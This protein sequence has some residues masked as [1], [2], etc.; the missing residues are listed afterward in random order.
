MMFLPSKKR[1]RLL[2][3]G[4]V[5]RVRIGGVVK[6]S[7]SSWPSLCLDVRFPFAVNPVPTDSKVSAFAVSSGGN[8]VLHV[9]RP[10]RWAKIAYSVVGPVSVD[11]VGVVL[12]KFA[13][14][15]HPRKPVGVVNDFVQT[16]AQVAALHVPRNRSKNHALPRFGMGEYSGVGVVVKKLAQTLRGKIG[17][18]HDALLM[19]IGQRPACVGSTCGL[20]Y[21]NAKVAA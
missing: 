3:C 19:L 18:S 21:F 4:N 9:L 17:L 7:N 8:L 11:V 12:R 6:K 16:D 2:L 5:S 13:M 10:S 14:H 20:R 1:V 15:V